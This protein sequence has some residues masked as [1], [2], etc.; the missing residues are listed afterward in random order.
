[1]KTT[2]TQAPDLKKL[3]QS[4]SPDAQA[5]I[6]DR[7][8]DLTLADGVRKNIE[9][10]GRGE[11]IQPQD[12]PVIVRWSFVEKALVEALEQA[13]QSRQRPPPGSI[14]PHQRPP[15]TPASFPRAEAFAR[16]LYDQRALGAESLARPAGDFQEVMLRRGSLVD[17][18]DFGIL[19]S[20]QPIQTPMGQANQFYV[21]TKLAEMAG[22]TPTKYF[23]PF[24]DSILPNE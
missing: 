19:V 4:L 24:D 18:E 17:G 9:R 14:R 1:M 12:G 11:R 6:D 21:F 16:F 15:S 23:G 22:P 7:A 5:A 13:E 20:K 2:T 3:Y 8:L 10:L